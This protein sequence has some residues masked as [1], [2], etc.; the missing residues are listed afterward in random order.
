MF[1]SI[2][3]WGAK[4]SMNEIYNTENYPNIKQFEAMASIKV[5][6]LWWLSCFQRRWLISTINRENMHSSSVDG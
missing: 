5:H 1:K 4:E 3:S 6:I 2:E